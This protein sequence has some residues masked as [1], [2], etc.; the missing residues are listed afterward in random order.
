MSSPQVKGRD[1]SMSLD[2]E[3]LSGRADRL[4]RGDSRTCFLWCLPSS[5]QYLLVSLLLLEIRTVGD[6]GGWSSL[7]D[8]GRHSAPQIRGH[9]HGRDF[10]VQEGPRHSVKEELASEIGVMR[11]KGEDFILRALRSKYPHYV[12]ISY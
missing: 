1:P 5:F 12:P 11:R 3:S 6:Q 4:W 10:R 8:G 7:Q 9:R 2:Q